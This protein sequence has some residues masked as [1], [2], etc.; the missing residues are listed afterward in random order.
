MRKQRGLI[1]T[2]STGALSNYPHT[3]C[4]QAAIHLPGSRCVWTLPSPACKSFSK[5]SEPSILL[6][7]PSSERPCHPPDLQNGKRPLQHLG[8]PTVDREAVLAR[9]TSTVLWSVSRGLVQT[10]AGLRQVIV[11]LASESRIGSA[12]AGSLQLQIIH[13]GSPLCSCLCDP[14]W[15][16]RSVR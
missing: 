5:E 1:D 7:P 12:P 8:L 9:R 2:G 14:S 15:W 10:L 13:V 3:G 6:L 11:R 4:K 16:P